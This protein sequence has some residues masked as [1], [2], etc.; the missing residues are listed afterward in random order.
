MAEAIGKVQGIT[1]DSKEEIYVAM[2]LDELG[3]GYDYQVGVGSA[4]DIAGTYVIDFVVY[5][6]FAIPLEVFGDYWHAGEM[7][8]QEK[9][10]LAIIEGIYHQEVLIVWG[11]KA[12]TPEKALKTVREL[13]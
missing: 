7:S 2:A 8:T 9:Y 3:Y 4:R 10:R 12:D 13:L 1:P 6:P 11:G 5:T